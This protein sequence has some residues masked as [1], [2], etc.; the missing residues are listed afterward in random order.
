MLEANIKLRLLSNL[1]CAAWQFAFFLLR[2][3]SRR[4]A[5]ALQPKVRL[6]SGDWGFSPAEALLCERLL[7]FVAPA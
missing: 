7:C 3:S 4:V 6:L 1:Q 5:S 2:T